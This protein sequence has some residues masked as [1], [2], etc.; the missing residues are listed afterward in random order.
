M[1]T[2]EINKKKINGDLKIAGSL[3]GIS[4]QNAYAALN[5]EGSKHHDKIKEILTKVI[6]MRENLKN[7][8]FNATDQ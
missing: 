8:V 3:V 1:T 7:E 5:R 4:A 6:E 2:E